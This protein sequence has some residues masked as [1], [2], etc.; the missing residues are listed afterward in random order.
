MKIVG[1]VIICLALISC[2]KKN[3]EGGSK[4]YFLEVTDTIS[5]P[6]GKRA[7]V[8]TFAL[9]PF[10]YL[11]RP[12]LSFL[13]RD[14][15]EILIY[16]LD[17]LTLTK[18]I[19][20]QR[21]GDQGVGNVKGFMIFSPD[22]IYITS[23]MQRI[24]YI[25]NGE[26]EVIRKIPYKTT[27]FGED[28]EMAFYS[29][30]DIQTPLIKRGSKI[31]LTN[32][33]F[34]NYTAQSSSSL[35]KHPVCIELDVK[36]GEARFLPMT[37]MADYW[38]DDNYYEPS[39]ARIFNGENFV[40]S[41]RYYNK[42]LVTKDHISVVEHPLRSRYF[43]SFGKVPLRNDVTEH[44]RDLLAS[45][46]YYNIIWDSYRRL[47]YVFALLGKIEVGSDQEVMDSCRYLN[48]FSVIILD[49]DFSILGETLMPENRYYIENF[50]VG[51]RG[52]YL[53]K[54]HPKSPSYSDDELAF[55][56]LTI[57]TNK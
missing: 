14:E 46:A 27:V 34:G 52:L 22:S 13:N 37:Y 53:S 31:Y 42:L 16:S 54:A 3:R 18:K 44:L 36:T 15:N 50:F 49:E 7:L 9:F 19:T 5:L 4:E 47:Y 6:V 11:N 41:W 48:S 29:R 40:Y 55:D 35:A 2:N 45:P 57:A 28:I 10:Q 33:I 25:V 21:E 24:I 26:G 20:L 32:Y 30:S 51:E 56:I 23:Q 17:S 8:H 12:Y 1:I 38:K 43:K 39:Y